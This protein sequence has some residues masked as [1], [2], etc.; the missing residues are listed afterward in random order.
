MGKRTQFGWPIA[1]VASFLAVGVPYWMIPYNEVNLPDALMTPGLFVVVFASLVMRAYGVASFWKA[2]SIVGAAV[3]A[4]VLARVIWDGV[5]D[6]TSHNLWPLE[7]LI[8]LPMGLG[9]ALAGAI[10]GSLLAKLPG[11]ADRG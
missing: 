2:A 1:F 8:A 6:P 11:A 5:Q 3:P 9:C 10:A 4:A 7:I